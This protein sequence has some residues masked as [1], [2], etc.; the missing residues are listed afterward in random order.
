MPLNKPNQT[1]VIKEKHLVE[2]AAINVIYNEQYEC[3]CV[4]EREHSID[5]INTVW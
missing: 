4:R 1:N 3:V 5:L 2:W